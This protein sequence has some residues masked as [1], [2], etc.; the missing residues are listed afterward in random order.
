MDRYK[1][2]AS[3]TMI[4]AAGQFS[5]KF[6]VYIMMRFYTG[7]LGTDGYG[8]VGIIVDASVIIMAIVTLSVNDSVVRFGLD[9]KYDKSQVFSIGLLTTV[10]GV[11]MFAAVAPALT[12]IDLL[13]DYVLLIYLY[14]FTGS[15]KSCCA[16][17][18]RSAGYVR[19]FALDG[20]F[21]TVVN[22]IFNL[23]FMLGFKMGVTGY[24]LS[25]VVA[26][27]ASI[28]FLF[29]M[30]DLKRY[31]R[32]WGLDKQLR[33]LMFKF[34][35][36]LIPTA[37][38]WWVTNA[39]DGFII[40]EILG[41]HYTGL[42]KAAYRIPN[43]IILISLIFSQAWNMSAITEKNS[44]TISQFYT[45]VFNIFQS[46]VYIMAAGMLLLIRPALD[47]MTSEDFAGVYEYSPLLVIAV[48]FACFS[49]FMGSV[50]VASKKTVRSML[51]A[52]SGATANI[53]LNLLLIPVMGIQGAA[54]ATV[55][56][57]VIIFTIRAVDSRKIVLM[58]LKLPKII[59]NMSVV[60]AMGVI[61]IFVKD[62]TLFYT[63]LSAGFA[64][65]AIL[66][67]K[68]GIAAIYMLKRKK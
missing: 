23:I 25:V 20:M 28:A 34:S 46:A 42:Y 11:L 41:K 35:L 17:F 8:A 4:L 33:R 40:A 63:S 15:I 62:V 67:F 52:F 37:I 22:I 7:E 47:L 65:T 6:L 54:L 3:N 10:I 43:I 31:F 49:T 14:V 61:V 50:Y 68:A 57:Y 66:N 60:T 27:A 32:I 18:A 45:N 56:S 38:M 53:A 9:K 26:D 21:T 59:V 19:L 39:S 55:I 64:V 36:P 12:L 30:A 51:T 13:K 16:L 2:L 5:S 1:K 48:V 58:D 24:V 29:Y 44:R